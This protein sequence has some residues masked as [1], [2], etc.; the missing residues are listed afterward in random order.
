MTTEIPLRVINEDTS[1]CWCCAAEF[2]QAGTSLGAKTRHTHH[3]IPG[4]YGGSDGPLVDICI[5]DHDLLHRV[6]K[7][8]I[9]LGLPINVRASWATVMAGLGL[10]EVWKSLSPIHVVRL[11]WL[12][13]RVVEAEKMTRGDVNKK[14]K[15]SLTLSAETSRKLDFLGKIFNTRSRAKTLVALIDGLHSKHYKRKEDS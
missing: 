2:S 15:V 7:R 12:V 4:A 13:S 5:E 11:H 1:T 10:S 3:I 9:T 14:V 6:A 8:F